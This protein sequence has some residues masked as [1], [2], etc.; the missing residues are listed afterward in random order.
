MHS[1]APAFLDL[2]GRLGHDIARSAIW[3]GGRCNWVGA[4]PRDETGMSGRAELAALGSDLYGGTSGVALFLAEAASQLDDAHL[5]ATALGAIRLALDH[6]GRIDPKAHDGLYDGRVGIA[7]AA[8]RIARLLDAEDIHPAARRLLAAWRRDGSLSASSDVMSGCAGAVLGLVA[9]GELVPESWLIDT[10]ARLGDELVARA[11]GSAAGWSW[12]APGQRSMHSLCGYAHG[13]AGIGHA[14]AELFSVTGEV[15][16]RDAALRAFDFERSWLDARSG[17]WPDLRGVARRAG[18]DAPV[19]ASDSWCNGA[20]GIA[21]SRLRAAD[22][23]F[24]ERLR[25]EADIALAACE[26]HVRELLVLAADDFSLCHG[27]AGAADVLVHADG[28]YLAA[29]LGRRGI[30]LYGR[31]GFPCGVPL[32]DT[33]GLLLGSSG[34]ALFYLRLSRPQVPSALLIHRGAVDSRSGG[35]LE[36]HVPG[37][38][39]VP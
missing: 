2:A 28:R 39:R 14:L 38:R 21:L 4:V 9:L 32:G 24:S 15:R 23:L 33:P 25:G 35:C 31:S 8:S 13:A 1:D 11:D 37:Q 3:F 5:R 10:A 6:A 26:R 20:V 17:T 12:P 22:L 27:A 30:D 29:R 19:P 36:S 7:Y 16:F 18:R 34:I